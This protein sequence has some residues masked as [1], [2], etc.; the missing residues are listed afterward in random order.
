MLTA[1]RADR[2]HVASSARSLG[3][4]RQAGRLPAAPAVHLFQGEG[5]GGGGGGVV[6]V[7]AALRSEVKASELPP[8]RRCMLTSGPALKSDVWE[9]IF[10]PLRRTHAHLHTH[11]HTHTH[12]RTS[13]HWRATAAASR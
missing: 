13:A 9:L 2:F 7:A 12:A 3:F 1:N 5:G 4:C 10:L 8:G 6:A 11:L